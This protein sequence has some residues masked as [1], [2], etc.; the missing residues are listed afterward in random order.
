M[1]TCEFIDAK[2]IVKIVYIKECVNPYIK[3]EFEEIQENFFGLLKP[4]VYPEGFYEITIFEKELYEISSLK[5]IYNIKN[6]TVYNKPYIV[7]HFNGCSDKTM[8]K[9]DSND[10][11]EEYILMLEN[12]SGKKF[13]CV[14]K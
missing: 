1:N 11:A 12:A 10:E 4:T 8:K 14:T 7:I 5:E 9:F 2:S 6:H 13:L 3:W